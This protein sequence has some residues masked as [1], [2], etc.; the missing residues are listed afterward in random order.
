M[1][2]ACC[3][4]ALVG[5][6]TAVFHPIKPNRKR[7]RG[8]EGRALSSEEKEEKGGKRGKR[9]R[10]KKKGGDGIVRVPR[11]EIYI[12][13]VLLLLSLHSV[14]HLPPGSVHSNKAGI[15]SPW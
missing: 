11:T 15:A 10:Q 7:G 13:A 5:T 4:C 1:Y 8:G 2:R 9:K 6:G 12:P 3:K 14:V